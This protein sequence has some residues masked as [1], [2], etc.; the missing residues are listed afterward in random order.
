MESEGDVI[1]ESG[2]LMRSKVGEACFNQN[3]LLLAPNLVSHTPNS[4]ALSYVF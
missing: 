2:E 4:H 3:H 1:D